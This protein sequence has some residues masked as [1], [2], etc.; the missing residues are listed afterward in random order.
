M[1]QQQAFELART[2]NIA[3]GILGAVIGCF[4][5]LIGYLAPRGKARRFVLGGMLV[6]A[7]LG[8]GALITGAILAMR[9]VPFVVYWPVLLMGIIIPAVI[10]PMY[11]VVR[12]RYRE[13][14]S[15]RMS[16]AALRA[17]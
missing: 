2:L 11:A 17:S 1:D 14:E 7:G 8:V 15:R 4:G 12:Q 10:V 3:G 13:A 16:A 5:G 6:F 9:G